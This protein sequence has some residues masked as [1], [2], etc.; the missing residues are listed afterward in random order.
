MPNC[1]YRGCK[2]DRR[3]DESV[4]FVPFP[5]PWVD[6]NRTKHWIKLCG[7]SFRFD[8]VNYNYYVCEKHFHNHEDLDPKYNKTLEP[9]PFDVSFGAKVST[10]E[11]NP[12]P[13]SKALAA[14]NTR[15]AGATSKTY[16]RPEKI[17]HVAVPVPHVPRPIPLSNTSTIDCD[18]DQPGQLEHAIICSVHVS[19][20][21]ISKYFR[22]C[23]TT[24]DGVCGDSSRSD[25][26]SITA[27]QK[28]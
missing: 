18:H 23:K 1:A 20:N 16:S 17:V 14:E 25:Q 22:H 2:S 24:K 4:K 27:P 9:I 15:I 3:R 12:D 13:D 7:R 8:K 21:S 5:K 26:R 6:I 10:G 28:D 19:F 11:T